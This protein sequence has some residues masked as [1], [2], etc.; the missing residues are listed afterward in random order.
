LIFTFRLKEIVKDRE[1]FTSVFS[2]WM[3]L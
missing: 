2:V 3:D 1:V